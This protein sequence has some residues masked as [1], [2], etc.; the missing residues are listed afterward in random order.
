ERGKIAYDK[1]LS[2]KKVLSK[3][4]GRF[5]ILKS[6]IATLLSKTKKI[7]IRREEAYYL[8]LLTN[9]DSAINIPF[10][11][12]LLDYAAERGGLSM[13]VCGLFLRR[14]CRNYD[15]NHV[16][17]ASPVVLPRLQNT[18]RV[19]QYVHDLMPLQLTQDPIE[20]NSPRKFAERL[21]RIVKGSTDFITNSEDTKSKLLEVFPHV[22]A[23][24]LS[25]G[26]LYLLDEKEYSND[27]DEHVL[28]KHGVDSGGYFFFVSALE[29]RKNIEGL[30]KGYLASFKRT[31]KPLLVAGS[32]GYEFDEIE[33][34]IS[35]LRPV[36]KA[37]I[38]FIGYISESEK[39][40]LLRH[41]SIFLFP[42]FYEG[43]GLPVLEAYALGCPVITADR[44]GLKEAAG[45]AALL[46]SDPHDHY[47]IGQRIIEL[48]T[49]ESKKA[50]LINAG[51]SQVMKFEPARFVVV[52]DE[53]LRR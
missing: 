4:I 11:F 30:I 16:L 34:L 43:F 37:H 18:V 22:E 14:L 29:K 47:E 25:P 2:T 50:D 51:K 40:T 42:S 28:Q 49:D 26:P 17:C 38:K 39:V 44:G 9:A 52:L 32:K 1:M 21:R 23:A 7:G 5:T 36:Q 15:I 27:I 33:K 20:G 48:D 53:F 8:P 10:I 31:K 19:T 45:E 24:V 6:L 13:W 35:G 3:P 46:I 41:A 12:Q